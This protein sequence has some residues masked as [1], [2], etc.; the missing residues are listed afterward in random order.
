MQGEKKEKDKKT[1]GINILMSGT[2]II[3]LKKYY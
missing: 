1:C 3:Y 2:K